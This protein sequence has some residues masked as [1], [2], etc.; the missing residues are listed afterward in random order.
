MAEPAARR[1]RKKR[2]KVA[3][4]FGRPEFSC[5]AC[6]DEEAQGGD[7]RGD[8]SGTP[9]SCEGPRTYRFYGGAATWTGCPR[10]SLGVREDELI[11]W[12]DRTGGRLSATELRGASMLM[13]D[14]FEA[15]D[16][17]RAQAETYERDRAKQKG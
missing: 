5:R 13:V 15:L 11:R 6:T 10:R 4:A 16:E 8:R 14:A 9:K 1:G 7:P 12:W 3:A 17:L 2:L